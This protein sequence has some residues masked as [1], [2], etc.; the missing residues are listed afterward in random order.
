M[1][2]ENSIF[3]LN[4]CSSTFKKVFIIDNMTIISG[5]FQSILT[6]NF[7]LW[8]SN[9]NIKYIQREVTKRFREIYTERI[10]LEYDYVRSMLIHTL[11]TWNSGL[12]LDELLEMVVTDFINDISNEIQWQQRFNNCEPRTLYFPGSDLTREDKIKLNPSRKL[13]F[14]MNY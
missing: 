4:I 2:F 3:K 6:P 13:V 8:V 1:I 14:N 9:E 11:T 12:T 10:E 5:F 7:R